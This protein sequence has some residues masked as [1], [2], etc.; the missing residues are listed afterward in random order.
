MQSDTRTT[1]V[2]NYI[3]HRRPINPNYKRWKQAY[4]QHLYHMFRL[5]AVESQSRNMNTLS[6]ASFDS[7][8]KF[9]F[10]CSSKHIQTTTDY[11]KSDSD[12]SD[13]DYDD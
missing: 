6:P 8:C 3:P 11:A 5:A 7:F 2:F 12:D 10:S 9:I 1:A 13:S 4:Y